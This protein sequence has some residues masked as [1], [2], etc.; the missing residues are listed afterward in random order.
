MGDRGTHH[1]FDEA[2]DASFV[3]TIANPDEVG[4]LV[5]VPVVLVHRYVDGR[6]SRSQGRGNGSGEQAEKE[7]QRVHCVR[8]VSKRLRNVGCVVERRGHGRTSAA[9]MLDL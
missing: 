8:E 4:T 6:D 3:G 2:H 7:G 9:A 5:N 1:A